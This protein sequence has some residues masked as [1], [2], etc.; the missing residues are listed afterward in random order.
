MKCF[1]RKRKGMTL[2]ETMVALML[3]GF[4]VI[5]IARLTSARISETEILETQYTVQA[6]DGFLYNIYQDY[7]KSK[8]FEIMTEPLVRVNED[9]TETPIYSET[10]DPIT[11]E[12][13]QLEVFSGLAFDMGAYGA[14]LYSYDR[15]TGGCYV[16]G[17]LVFK[18]ENFVAE[19]TKQFLFVSIKLPNQKVFEYE[20]YP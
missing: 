1:K 16:N 17:S 7:H 8:S 4:A 13:K 10:P 6:V 15:K 20:I 18:C 9:G 3:M 14:S 2:V 11:G 12:Y 19:G 5:V